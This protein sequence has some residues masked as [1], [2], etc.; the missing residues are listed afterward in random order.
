MCYDLTA[1]LEHDF[2]YEQVEII[3]F[4]LRGDTRGRLIIHSLIA[5]RLINKNSLQLDTLINTGGGK[6]NAFM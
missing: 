5:T 4:H 3:R 6:Y 1:A 2:N